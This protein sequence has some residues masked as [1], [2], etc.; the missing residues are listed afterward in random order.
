MKEDNP[1]LVLEEARGRFYLCWQY[2][3]DTGGV[4]GQDPSDGEGSCPDDKDQDAWEHW[5]ASKAIRSCKE[6]QRD[7]YGFYFESEALAKKALRVAKAALKADKPIPEWAEKALAAG[8]KPP[9][10]WKP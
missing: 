2:P 7:P 1:T 4:L 5:V 6:V 9:K 8:W 10:G 3:E